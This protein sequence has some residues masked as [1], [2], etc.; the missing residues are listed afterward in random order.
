MSTEKSDIPDIPAAVAAKQRKAIAL[1]PET[2]EI[3]GEKTY[4]N[5]AGDLI[6]PGGRVLRVDSVSRAAAQKAEEYAGPEPLRGLTKEQIEAI[7]MLDAPDLPRMDPRTGDRGEVFRNALWAKYPWYAAVRFAYRAN[8]WPTILP[9]S[10]PAKRP[11]DWLSSLTIAG[12]QP[13]AD[14]AMQVIK[15]T[16]AAMKQAEKPQIMVLENGVLR[17]AT[18]DEL[19]GRVSQ[20]NRRGRKP[21]HKPTDSISPTN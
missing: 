10:W 5:E 8:T 9:A 7:K 6:Q 21:A 4:M 14:P 19:A 13:Q 20:P 3:V 16:D 18:P 17:P 15:N 11:A 2:A 1:T 12:N